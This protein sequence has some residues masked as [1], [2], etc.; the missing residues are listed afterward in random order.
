MTNHPNRNWRSRWSVDLGTATVTH[1]D[2][3]QFAFAPVRG[4]P[5]A[6][7]GRCIA[8]PSPMTAEH[9]RVATRIAREAGDAYIEAR[10]GRQ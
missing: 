2:G 5:A 9:M 1:C 8:Q 3:W 6:F 4:D 10:R 7:D